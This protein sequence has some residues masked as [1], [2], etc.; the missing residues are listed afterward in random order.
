MAAVTSLVIEIGSCSITAERLVS[1]AQ[2]PKLLQRP[3]SAF[4][5]QCPPKALVSCKSQTTR[6]V[7]PA[8][9]ASDSST[10]T[11]AAASG[12][13]AEYLE[14]LIESDAGV[15]Y[16]H[17]Q[18]KLAAGQWEEAD[19]ETRR[20]LC[21][22]AGEAAAKR[23]WVYFTEV[24]NIP[25]KDLLTIDRLWRAYS[26]DRFGF[27][28]QRKMWR[29]MSR[30]WK[31]LFLQ[32]GWTYGP[33]STYKKFPMEFTWELDAPVGHLPLTN[34][35]RGTQ[36]IEKLFTHPAMSAFDADETMPDLDTVPSVVAAEPEKGAASPSSSGA[37]GGTISAQSASVPFGP[38]PLIP[39]RLV[40][41]S[42]AV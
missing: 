9:A 32:I 18:D 16:D 12:G 8:I 7:L 23:K 5:A 3:R 11:S 19:N 42:A 2:A 20:L 26:K 22:L 38:K 31:P 33:N 30:Q 34:A 41:P 6:R 10:E 39:H 36:L 1:Q 29:A 4:F 14:V 37:V 28:V 24:Q 25:D 17:L 21:V 27:S 35:L 15:S 40:F 13:A